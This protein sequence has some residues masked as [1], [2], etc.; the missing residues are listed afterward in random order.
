MKRTGHKLRPNTKNTRPE[1]LI[2]VDTETLPRK[3]SEGKTVH[4]LRLGVGIFVRRRRDG[5]QDTRDIFRF[6]TH[7]EF[8]EWVSSKTQQESIMYMIAHNVGFDFTV[9]KHI[10]FLTRAGYKC[11]F[12]FEKGMAFIAKWRKHNHTIYL[13]DNANWFPGK[14]EYVA[15]QMNYEKLEMPNFS[16]PD[17]VWFEYCQKDTEILEK[18]Y[19]HWINF[20]DDHNLGTWRYTLASCAFNAYRH[21]FMAFPIYLPNNDNET[22]LARESYHGGRTECFRVGEYNNATFYK[23]DVNSMYPAVMGNNAYPS[24]VRGTGNE[25]SVERL[26]RIL[27]KNAVIATV[28]LCVDEPWFVV[29]QDKRNVY[30]IGEFTTELTTPELSLALKRKWIKEIHSYARYSMRPLFTEYVDFF[31]GLKLQYEKED[32]RLWRTIC[33]LFLNSLYGKFGQRG[34]VDKIIGEAKPGEHTV[35]YGFNTVTKERYMIRQIGK[36]VMYSAQSGEGYNSFCAVASHVTAYARIFLYELVQLAKRENCFYCDTD[37]LIV[38]QEGFNNLEQLIHPTKL[39][40]LKIEGVAGEIEIIAPK[41]YRFGEKIVRKGIRKNAAQVGKNTFVQEVWPGLNTILKNGGESYFTY[42]Q[43]KTLN[44]RIT[45]GN[46]DTLGF[47]TPFVL[48]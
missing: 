13:L 33:K 25:L 10:T 4:D 40:A 8:W 15:E 7:D 35:S 17:D 32:N 45:S 3:K 46:I 24:Q 44:P 42:K 22:N 39:G 19:H 36:N 9:L 48:T 5:E 38:N 30:P 31:Y 41:H 1:Y 18:L 14:L 16:D 27:G 28:S 43:Q 23:L 20:M 2:F 34:Y 47:V 11:L 26:S 21:R 12:V 37:S 29:K 6:T